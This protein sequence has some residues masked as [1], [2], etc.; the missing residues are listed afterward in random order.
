MTDVRIRMFVADDKDWL[1]EQHRFLYARDEGFDETF[2]ALVSDILD[3]FIAH[4]DPERE[5]GWIAEDD[6]GR[7]GSVFCTHTNEE[8]ARLRM[9]LLV[10]EARGQGLGRRLLDLCISHA[11][12]QGYRDITLWTH[13]SHR[14]ACALYAAT[15]WQIEDSKATR[16][17]GQD[18]VEQNWRY[19]L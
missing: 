2:G 16:S 4:H 15:G 10:P 11:R 12:D 3:D 7:L 5:R 6:G 19:R 13:E 17:F 9:F 14:A 18:V 8:T 1:L